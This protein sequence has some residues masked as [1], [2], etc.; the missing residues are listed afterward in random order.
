MPQW[1]DARFARLSIRNAE[2]FEE[3]CSF[4]LE[5][6]QRH[7]D[8]L[9]IRTLLFLVP[10]HM[11]VVD[12][13][14]NQN[15]LLATVRDVHQILTRHAEERGR[16]MHDPMQRLILAIRALPR[17]VFIKQNFHLFD[18]LGGRVFFRGGFRLD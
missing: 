16:H 13:G 2:F 9:V 1:Q 17:L 4:H 10:D 18:F 8:R 7:F 15:G 12:A 14:V 3:L 5:L 11:R 6:A